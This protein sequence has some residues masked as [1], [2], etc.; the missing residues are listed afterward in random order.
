MEGVFRKENDNSG[1]ECE[2]LEDQGVRCW[3]QANRD[4]LDLNP[5]PQFSANR[6]E[7]K[8]QPPLK[9]KNLAKK[10][11]TSVKKDRKFDIEKEVFVDEKS[12]R[13]SRN[14]KPQLIENVKKG[15]KV[16]GKEANLKKEM[17]E[18]K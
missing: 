11:K 9:Y 13:A 8:D 4:A 5:D 17:K 6:D 14:K 7:E 15:T 10:T 3:A 1:E 16:K 12:L 2:R 18:L